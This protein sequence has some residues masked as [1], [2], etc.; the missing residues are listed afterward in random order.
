MT[1]DSS[2]RDDA[3]PDRRSAR[4]FPSAEQ[5]SAHSRLDPNTPQT[6][7]PAYRLGFA[8]PDFL[9]RDDLR[10]VRLQLEFLKPDLLQRDRGVLA[11]VAVFG[12]ARVPAPDDAAAHLAEA[13]RALAEDP[14]DPKLAERLRIVRSLAEKCRYYD[15][16]R[17]LA[18][19]IAESHVRDSSPEQ[20]V[21]S[22]PAA[23]P[24]RGW[25]PEAPPDSDPA[26]TCKL[27][28]GPGSVVVVTGGGPGIMEAA[29]RGAHDADGDSIG[30]NIVLPREQA[31]NPYITPHLCF[32]FHYYALRKMHFLLRAVA[33]VVFPGGYGTLDELFEVLTLIQTGKIEPIPVLLFGRDY[34]ER[35][36]HFQTLA[37]EGMIEPK[38]LEI[39]SYVET[40]EEAWE[41]LRPVLAAVRERT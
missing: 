26:D 8:D 13:Q 20:D 35:I 25:E 30:L 33:L 2:S 10:A 17:N 37:D 16:A 1:E 15:E 9:L 3:Q 4:R 38:D 22:Q 34:W 39:F 41:H 5:D 27:Y 28:Y 31:P 14:S 18:R 23:E 11:T 6:T 12:S 21:K 29:N 32:N 40:A 19:L 7:S 36:I 24:Q